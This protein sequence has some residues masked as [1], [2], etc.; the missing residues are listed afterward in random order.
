[1]DCLVELEEAH[2]AA[3]ADTEWKEFAGILIGRVSY[4]RRRGYLRLWAGRGFGLSEKI[5][6]AIYLQVAHEVTDHILLQE[7]YWFT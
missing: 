3:L 6:E 5:C 1:M 4:M 2:E 7:P